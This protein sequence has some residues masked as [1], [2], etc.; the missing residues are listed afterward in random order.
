MVLW[1]I[2]R[3]E[4]LELPY[5]YLGYWIE[6]SPKMAYKARFRPL[7]GLGPDGWEIGQ[8]L[9]ANTTPQF[10]RL[11]L[12]ALRL[13]DNMKSA[14]VQTD[15]INKGAGRRL[16]MVNCIG[17]TGHEQENRRAEVTN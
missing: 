3:A 12:R 9:K 1:M 4:Q 11:T 10:C 8:Q 17:G 5:V 16:R 13:A 6:E 7:E 15:S 14:T 2:R